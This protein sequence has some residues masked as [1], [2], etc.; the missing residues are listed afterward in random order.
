[1][2]TKISYIPDVLYRY[3]SNKRTNLIVEGGNITDEDSLRG[4]EQYIDFIF[5]LRNKYYEIE[6]NEIQK[7]WYK[8][9]IGILNITI[10]NG[11]D[12]IE[13]F[14]D[15]NLSRYINQLDKSK[16]ISK[17]NLRNLNINS[18]SIKEENEEK[19]N[20][21]DT[22]T[23]TNAISSFIK[24]EFYEN[25]QIKNIYLPKYLIKS[26][27]VF[28]DNIIKLLIPKLSPSLYIKNIAE[29]LKELNY[30]IS[31]N[32]SN[33]E[34]EEDNNDE[35]YDTFN[36]IYDTDIEITDS[37]N[38]NEDS[39]ILENELN[40]EKKTNIN[41]RL[42][43]KSY[44]NNIETTNLYENDNAEKENDD[45]VE[46]S[47]EP[48]NV[49]ESTYIDL[50][51]V[52]IFNEIFSLDN[53]SFN[54]SENITIK[55][56]TNLTE[57]FSQPLENDEMSLKD[58]EV[59]TIIYSSIDDKGILFAIKEIQTAAM[60]QPDNN[61][62]EEQKKEEK[63]RNDIY[64]SNNQISY[65]EANFEEKINNDFSF[66]LTK[67]SM[68]SE[69]NIY[70]KSTIDN[71]E[72]RHNLYK[73]F[74]EFEYVLYNETNNTQNKLRVLSSYDVDNENI[75]EQKEYEKLIKEY[76]K[77]RKRKLKRKI[78]YSDDY[79]G[80]KTFTYEKEFFNYNLLGLSLKGN[81]VCEIE[82]S[83]GIVHNYFNLGL[84]RFNKKFNLATQQT[85]L[86][87][88]IERLNKMTFDFISLLYQSNNNL[89]NNNKKYGDVIIEIEKN[90]SNLF[91]KYFD[92]SGIFTDSL[93]NLYFQ[94]SN[95]TGQFL[96]D[97]ITLIDEVH[98]NYTIIFLK[99][100][101][102]SYEFINEIREI[103]KDA[104]IEYIHRMVNNLNLFNNQTLSFL[105][106]IKEETEKIEIF[107]IDLLYDIIDLIY[108]A[109][110]IFRDF[111]K[112]LFKAIEKGILTFKYDIKD[113]I[114]MII[115]ELYG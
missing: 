60:N 89:N 13:V 33:S 61:E 32:V 113:Q 69:N 82:P 26:N 34:Y 87:I 10:N 96:T 41:R 105:D 115:G 68:E 109:K 59:N 98:S 51:E 94:V 48:K 65:D 42:E 99:G 54:I 95:F 84:S 110:I 72:L 83:T 67:I 39:D 6:N 20:D 71:D 16:I 43:D 28:I 55:N 78:S 9:Y 47:V 15:T 36:E 75:T 86:H 111:N 2:V 12:D 62:D 40:S 30:H 92:Y 91:D 35:I 63:L 93:D 85:N 8:G 106:N 37:N 3:Q 46:D 114:E 73:Y 49:T 108:D 44:V 66:N 24:I 77:E 70:L 90:V 97:L 18:D 11:T 102:D 79:Y 14:H 31:A 38:E 80:M 101:N 17:N 50:R 5:I 52:N 103:T 76:Q 81:A 27:M 107:Q 25:G 23:N 22:E 57:F 88:V 100:M 1:M 21:T 45:D 19:N 64:N 104:Y 56:Y 4:M 58:S 53:N 74:D 7:F 29:K 112:N